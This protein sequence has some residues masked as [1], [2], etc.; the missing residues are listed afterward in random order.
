MYADLH[1][2]TNSAGPLSNR[3]DQYLR[4]S[5]VNGIILDGEE[6]SRK[7]PAAD[8][9]SQPTKRLRPESEGPPISVDPSVSLAFLLDPG[10]PL[11]LY[12]AQVIPL[13]IV[14][15]IILRTLEIL[16][17]QTLEDRLNVPSSVVCADSSLYVLGY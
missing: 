9:L 4:T 10:N 1:C 7:R 12:D 16:P 3:I 14:T 2:R 5:Q 17:P 8:D 15:E 6:I 11:A 13:A